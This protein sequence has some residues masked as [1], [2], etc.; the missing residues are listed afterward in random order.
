MKR[1]LSIIFATVFMFSFG[2]EAF[3]SNGDVL[4]YENEEHNVKAY[5]DVD[6]NKMY[7]D[8]SLENASVGDE[9]VLYENE[10]TGDVVSVIYESYEPVIA[11]R[12]TGNSGWSAG[13]LSYGN[14]TLTPTITSGAGFVI[15]YEVLVAAYPVHIESVRKPSLTGAGLTIHNEPYPEILYADA[16]NTRPAETE[17]IFIISYEQYGINPGAIQ[18]YLTMEINVL[19]QVRT[20]WSY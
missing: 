3:A 20:S 19:G 6:T 18:G 7:A 13:Y 12:T 15:R 17:M 14:S 9:I 8:F 4:V 5:R 11:P 16:I 2:V 1:I 10:E